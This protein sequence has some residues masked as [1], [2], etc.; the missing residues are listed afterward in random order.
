MARRK[1]ADFT[2]DQTYGAGHGD[3]SLIQA[4]YE[5]LDLRYFGD[6]PVPIPPASNVR[7]THP[8]QTQALICADYI[9]RKFA[10]IALRAA[11]VCC[12]LPKCS[13]RRCRSESRMPC[14]AAWHRHAN[15]S[16][17]AEEESRRIVARRH[18]SEL[19][20]VS[21]RGSATLARLRCVL[22]S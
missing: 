16:C 21:C 10:P 2:L 5:Y 9:V 3:R 4:F 22:W 7:P 1:N 6:T 18:L 15:L 14:N 8:A 11:G 12:R 17:F 20:L 19:G 13:P